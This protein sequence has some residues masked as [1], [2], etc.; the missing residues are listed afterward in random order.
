MRSWRRP[1]FPHPCKCSIVGAGAFHFRVRDGNGWVRLAHAT[2]CENKSSAGA[3][4][5]SMGENC[6][7]PLPCQNQDLHD[8]EILRIFKPR[9]A[10]RLLHQVAETRIQRVAQRVAEQVESENRAEYG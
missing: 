5:E 1:I 2:K 10:A 9:S 4:R 7:S 6:K 8:S 3:E